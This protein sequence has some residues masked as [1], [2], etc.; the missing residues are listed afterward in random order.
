MNGSISHEGLYRWLDEVLARLD[1]ERV[2]NAFLYSLSTRD[3]RYRAHLACYIYAK[4]I[5][6]HEIV[7]E[8][9][10]SGNIACTYCG[11]CYTC[12]QDTVQL[13][14]ELTKWGGVRFQDVFTATY[15]LDAFSKMDT[16]YPRKADFDIFNNIID[17]IVSSQDEWRPRDLEKVL[18]KIFRSNKGERDMLINQ[19]GVVGILD[20]NTH[21]GFETVFTPPRFREVPSFSKIDWHYPVCWWRGRDRINWNVYQAVFGRYPELRQADFEV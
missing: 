2:T 7:T 17:V 13:E 14:S 15:Y 21:K 11:H 8:V 3:L 6:R 12:P 10:P 20:S 5:P 18:A 16:V 4:S 19:F 1:L 9:Y